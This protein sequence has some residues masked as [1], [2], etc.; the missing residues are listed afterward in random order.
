MRGGVWTRLVGIRS[1]VHGREGKLRLVH[2]SALR[3][4]RLLQLRR[5]RV[6]GPQR[7]GERGGRFLVQVAEVRVQRDRFSRSGK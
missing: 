4:L 7:A 2:D 6:L 5:E 3:A 1:H